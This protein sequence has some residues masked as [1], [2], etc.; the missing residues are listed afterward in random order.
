[1]RRAVQI[2]VTVG[3]L[4]LL[5]WSVETRDVLSFLQRIDLVY[6]GAALALLLLQN[7]LVTRRWTVVLSAF[8]APP[9]HFRMLRI[10]YLGLFAQLFLPTSIGGAFVRAGMLFRAGVSLGVAANSVILDRVV[11]FG[12]LIM[13]A[14]IFMPAVSVPWSVDPEVRRLGLLIAGIA[15]AGLVVAIVALKLQPLPYWIGLL[16]RT[17]V[18]HL[19]TPLR[20]AARNLASPYRIAAAL[21]FSLVAQMVTICAVFVL[22]MGMGLPVRLLD[23]LLIMPPVMLIS[24]LPI[25]VAGWGVREGAM[26]VA[27]GLLDV[28]KE[29]A[30]ALSVQFALLGYLA[31]TPGAAAWLVEVNSRRQQSS[32]IQKKDVG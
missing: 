8:V 4:A 6:G 1:M 15:T 14:V 29:A 20:D 28:P 9:G 16:S 5:A 21:A 24:S 10:V 22:A 3:L 11:A 25:S 18:R 13:L 30:L 17:P 31:A 27:F 7:E 26:V 19:L 12:G 2:S 32:D 23:C